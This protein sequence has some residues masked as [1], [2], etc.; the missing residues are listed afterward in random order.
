MTLPAEQLPKRARGGGL[1][2][3]AGTRVIDLTTSIAGPYAT[4]LLGDL[5]AEI[6]KVERPKIGDDS[7]HWK[8]PSY[9]GEALW[10]LSVNRNKRSIT[11]DFS[12]PAGRE[13][14]H[15]LI[16]K[17]DVLVTNQLPR[18]Q[19]KL[20]IDDETVRAL[21]P[22]LIFV[23]ITGFGLSGERSERPCYDLIAEGYSGVMDLTGEADA[24]PQKVGT[25]AADLLAGSDAAL[26]CLAALLDRRAIGAGHVVEISLVESMTRFM[27]PRIISYLGSGDVPKRSGARDSVI[28]IYQ[29]FATADDPITLALP[30]ENIWNRFCKAAGLAKLASEPRFKDNAARVA[31]RRELVALISG[32]LR[33]Q[34]RAHWLDLFA[35]EQIPAG[36]INR[37]DEVAR[38]PELIDR[39][40]FYAMPTQDGLPIPQVGLGIRFDDAAAGYDLPPPALG[41]DTVMILAQVL[42][43]SQNAIDELREKGVL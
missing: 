22:D 41:Q 39:G 35:R 26:G 30:N 10:Y 14:L 7:R 16:R 43:L 20:G 5:G 42:G 23:S 36:P 19:K 31:A 27:T 38:D 11:L 6:I 13:V 24:G 15:D 37:I 32:V 34:P 17:S 9:G 28:A 3:L 25:P 4:M 29:V 33:Q 21:K 2:L 1:K 12:V 8:P 18:V 40:L